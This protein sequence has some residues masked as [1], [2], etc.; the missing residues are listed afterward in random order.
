MKTKIDVDTIVFMR[1]VDK[2]PYRVI[3]EMLGTHPN[4]ARTLYE[5]RKYQEAKKLEKREVVWDDGLSVRVHSCL[6]KL[7]IKS[8][9]EAMSAVLDGRLKALKCPRNY[10]RKSEIELCEWLGIS[11]PVYPIPAQSRNAI[12]PHCN[13]KIKGTKVFDAR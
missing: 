11:V 1:D 5:K 2:I 4:Y 8:R 10:G 13:M 9:E 12:C 7:G 3:G 6:R